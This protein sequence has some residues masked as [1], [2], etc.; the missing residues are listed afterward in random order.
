MEATVGARS[1]G[2]A[3]LDHAAGVGEGAQ[4]DGTEP[5]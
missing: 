2:K 5:G 1:T 4:D 3:S